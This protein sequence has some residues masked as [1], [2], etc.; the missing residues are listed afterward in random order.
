MRREKV[1][2]GLDHME[3]QIEDQAAEF[4]PAS[5]EKLKRVDAILGLA[6]KTRN[7]NIRISEADLSQLKSRSEEEGL[8][9][10]TLIASILHKYVSNRLVD[11][12]SIRKSLNLLRSE[13]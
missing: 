9:Y 1:K 11:E 12:K 13:D 10:Q 5:P 7:I 4:Q 2:D 8:P 3:R 6:R